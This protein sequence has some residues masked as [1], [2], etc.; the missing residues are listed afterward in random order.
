MLATLRWRRSVASGMHNTMFN[1]RAKNF[2][3]R[4][5]PEQARLSGLY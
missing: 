5:S 2:D 1:A 3:T 4:A